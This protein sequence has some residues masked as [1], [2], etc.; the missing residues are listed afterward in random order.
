[1]S[2]ISF[3]LF[4]QGT[5]KQSDP[6]NTILDHVLGTQDHVSDFY[7]KD[8]AHSPPNLVIH[9]SDL[10]HNQIETLSAISEGDSEEVKNKPSSFD[11]LSKVHDILLNHNNV[12]DIG[13]ETFR[14]L[15]S[16]QVL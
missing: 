10:A 2:L 1:M 15:G 12:T 6:A 13:E 4:P 5:Q 3:F 9:S 14:G 7:T 16:L 8:E 11:G